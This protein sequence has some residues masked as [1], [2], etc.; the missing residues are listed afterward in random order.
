M[1]V[2]RITNGGKKIIGKFP[3][4]KNG[5]A[6]W[7][8]SQLERDLIHLLEI[9]PDVVSY[10]EQPFK[11]R[12]VLNGGIH[13]Y[14]PDFLVERTKRKQVV[15]VKTEKDAEKEE[16]KAVFARAA[17]I[18]QRD[19]YEF[20]LA[21]DKTIREQPR[22][23]NV[24]LLYKYSG[25]P[26]PN[27]HQIH[28]YAFFAKRKKSTIAEMVNFFASKGSGMQVVYALIYLGILWVDLSKPIGAKSIVS[29]PM[30]QY[31]LQ[32]EKIA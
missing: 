22:L 26:V 24:K 31:A 28:A 14:T 20:V 13:L 15:E 27:E 25:T 29:M 11:I 19:G 18:C 3:S 10:R 32:K 23:D 17:L 12:Y 5:R 2:R 16:N 6:V 1:S 21:T 7:Y 9:D 4:R 30:A 8:E